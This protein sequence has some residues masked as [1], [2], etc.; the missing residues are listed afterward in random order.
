[1]KKNKTTRLVNSLIYDIDKTYKGNL[2]KKREVVEL[3]LSH[4]GRKQVGKSDETF[5][6]TRAEAEKRILSSKY[7]NRNDV[8]LYLGVSAKYLSNVYG[9]FEIINATHKEGRSVLFRTEH[10]MRLREFCNNFQMTLKRIQINLETPQFEKIFTKLKNKRY[11]GL[12]CSNL[13]APLKKG[14]WV[15]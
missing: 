13:R 5:I 3:L 6:R 12:N 7:A 8:A 9:V 15:K 14:G 2:T 10:I 4:Y 11:T 1:M